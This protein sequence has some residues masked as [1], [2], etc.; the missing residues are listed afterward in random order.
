VLKAIARTVVSTLSP[1]TLKSLILLGTALFALSGTAVSAADTEFDLGVASYKNRDFKSA[2]LHFDYAL[3]R[4]RNDYNALYYKAA[5]LTQLGKPTEAKYIYAVLIKSFPSTS[6]ARNAEAAMA[7]LDPTYLRQLKGLSSATSRPSSSDTAGGAS[8]ITMQ[9]LT[10][11]SPS[12]G[13]LVGSPTP[14]TVYFENLGNNLL[15]QALINNRKVSMLFD[16]GAYGCTIGLEQVKEL[17]L[18]APEG[19]PTGRAGGV[20]GA[21]STGTWQMMVSLRVGTIEKRNFPIMVIENSNVPPLLGQTFFREYTYSIDNVAKSIRF[22][23]K[24]AD[25]AVASR[26]NDGSGIPFTREGNH[27]IVS[28][29]FNGKSIPCYL[30]TG[31]SGTVLTQKHCEELGLAIP[32]DAEITMSQGVGGVSMNKT[33]PVS[34][35]Q[36][37]PISKNDVTVSV[38]GNSLPHPLLGQNFFGNL[39]YEVDDENHVIRMRY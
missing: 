13:E 37:G 15:V 34:R 4:S 10:N 26:A 8:A 23:P 9:S 17:G 31:A 18:K 11:A 3:Q 21:G 16:S 24:Q 1:G 22:R 2:M 28:V 36:C 25:G 29:S 14:S 33:F 30:D 32:Q 19:P 39:R 6:A 5:C 7:Y 35:V 27:I 12:F 20:G 38:T